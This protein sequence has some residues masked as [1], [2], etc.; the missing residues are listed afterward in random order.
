MICNLYLSYRYKIRRNYG[1]YT[2]YVLKCVRV[3][4]MSLGDNIR[5]V[6]EILGLTREQVSTKTGISAT[7]IGSIE[8]DEKNPTIDIV[9]KL[10]KAYNVTVSELIGEVSLHKQT[11]N[12]LLNR[13]K[14]ADRND[15]YLLFKAFES[16][17]DKDVEIIL[18]L[19]SDFKR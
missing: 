8:R 5:H 6:R 14:F 9:I 2:F 17:N 3:I 10:A 19:I 11:I 13:V 15:M 16:L 12:S 1:L 7:H 4:E 18:K